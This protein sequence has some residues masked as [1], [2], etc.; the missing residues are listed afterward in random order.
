MF[1]RSFCLLAT[2]ASRSFST[3]ASASQLV[4]A[5]AQVYGTEGRY[6]AA[7]YSAASKQKALDAVEKDLKAYKEEQDDLHIQ[8]L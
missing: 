8:I 5:P 3:T 4:K 1:C 2:T 7:L 6:A